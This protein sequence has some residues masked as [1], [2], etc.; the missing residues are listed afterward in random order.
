MKP[1][2]PGL[3][4]GGRFIITVSNSLL[5]IEHFRFLFLHNSILIGCMFLGSY[6]FLLSYPFLGHIIDDSSLND[7]CLVLGWINVS[8]PPS[9][10]PKLPQKHFCPCMAAKL[11]LLSEDMSRELTILPSCSKLYYFAQPKDLIIWA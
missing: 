10:V 7:Y 2:N 4:F 5:I 1:T 8:Q 9:W 11:L 6:S 3:L